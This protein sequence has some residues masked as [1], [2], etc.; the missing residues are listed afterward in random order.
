[1]SAGNQRGAVNA[2]WLAF[3]VGI[4]LLSLPISGT[5]QQPTNNDAACDHPD[6]IEIDVQLLNPNY[7]SGESEATITL[8]RTINPGTY[9]V[10]LVSEDDHSVV[11]KQQT[12]EQ[13]RALLLDA[14]GEVVYTSSPTQDLPDEKDRNFITT[15]FPQQSVTGTATQLRVV[16]LGEGTSSNSIIARCAVFTHVREPLGRIVVEKKVTEPTNADEQFG[17]TAMYATFQLRNGE[18]H[19]SGLI[20]A[21]TYSVSEDPVNGWVASATCSDGSAPDAI[22]LEDGEVVICTFTNSRP[23][24][25]V[26][27]L[28]DASRGQPATEPIVAPGDSFDYVINVMNLGLV[29]ATNVNADLTLSEEVIVDTGALSPS[30]VVAGTD[31]I[32]CSFGTVPPGQILEIRVTVQVRA[33]S[34]AIGSM[35]SSVVVGGSEEESSNSNNRD[36]E[37][38][39]FPSV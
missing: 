24:D 26:V 35:T 28:D 6:A 12:K 31:Q 32:R 16:H 10:T 30:C 23:I 5:F 27:T 8:P 3:L 38:T 33:T 4:A 13:W 20:S 9:T 19:D 7:R 39:T 1:M 25:L 18:R 37:P 11:D 29:D 15:V 34:P 36:V 17:F 2:V 21:G 14:D 22:D